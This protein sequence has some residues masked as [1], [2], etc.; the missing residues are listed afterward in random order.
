MPHNRSAA[1]SREEWL[2]EFRAGGAVVDKGRKNASL[3]AA[4]DSRSIG[5]I[6]QALGDQRLDNVV[7]LRVGEMRAVQ[8]ACVGIPERVERFLAQLRILN[9]PRLP[10]HKF[11]G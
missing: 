5:W 11:V 8:N 9:S 1:R 3:C 2:R 7:F 10:E 4:I 6:Q